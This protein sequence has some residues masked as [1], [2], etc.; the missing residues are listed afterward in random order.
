MDVYGSPTDML[1]TTKET[2]MN[3]KRPSDAPYIRYRLLSIQRDD[4]TTFFLHVHYQTDTVTLPILA[5][6]HEQA[7][8]IYA[9][10]VRGRVTP[11]TLSDV[12]EDLCG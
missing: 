4:T 11:C 6:T 2:S 7:R 1:I 12:L 10:V 3:K 8:D 5:A 9:R